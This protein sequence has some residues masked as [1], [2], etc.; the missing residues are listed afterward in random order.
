MPFD[1]GITWPPAKGQVQLTRLH[2]AG[3]ELNIAVKLGKL[4]GSHP[5]AM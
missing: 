3:E 2:L 5:T 1:S 4:K